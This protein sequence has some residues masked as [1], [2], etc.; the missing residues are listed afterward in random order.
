MAAIPTPRKTEGDALVYTLTADEVRRLLNNAK[1]GSRFAIAVSANLPIAG[2]DDH[3]FPGYTNIKVG[4]DA[5]IAF[6]ADMLRNLE[7]RGARI[8]VYVYPSTSALLTGAYY[9]VG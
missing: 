7:E 8:K 1:T 9:V 5:A 3:C 6:A 4:C 2:D